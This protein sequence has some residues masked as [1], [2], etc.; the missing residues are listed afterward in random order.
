MLENTMLGEMQ[1]G[2]HVRTMFEAEGT[3]L[4]SVQTIRLTQ[5]CARNRR[6]RC[7]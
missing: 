3:E 1:V 7:C 6:G 2:K 5:S 4:T